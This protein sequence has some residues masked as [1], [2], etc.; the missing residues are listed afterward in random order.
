M[1]FT[2]YV[3]NFL[4]VDPAL[5][6]IPFL[7]SGLSIDVPSLLIVVKVKFLLDKE[8]LNLE[9]VLSL[10]GQASNVS[11]AFPVIFIEF[12]VRLPSASDFLPNLI[13]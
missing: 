2:T 12:V 4:S 3:E 8:I 1:I 5:I 6:E 11:L 7:K 9:L 13:D 10:Y